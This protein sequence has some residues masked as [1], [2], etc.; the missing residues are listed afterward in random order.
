MTTAALLVGNFL[1]DG[2]ANANDDLKA[3]TEY[4]PLHFF[5]GGQAITEINVNWLI[6]LLAAALAFSILAW[7]R[8]QRRDIRVGGEGGWSLPLLRRPSA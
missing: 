7:L 8:F 2:L 6:G 4:M 1:L 3:V 5:Q